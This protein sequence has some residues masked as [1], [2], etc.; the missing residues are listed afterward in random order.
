MIPPRAQ[1]MRATL[2]FLQA[3]AQAEAIPPALLA[4]HYWLDSWVG[5]GLIERGLV[6]DLLRHGSRALRHQSHRLGVG[7][8]AVAGRAG[9][10]V[11]GVEPGGGCCVAHHRAV[12]GTVRAGGADADRNEAATRRTGW[13]VI[14]SMF[15]GS[16]YARSSFS[17]IAA[18]VSG[19]GP[20]RPFSPRSRP[21]ITATSSADSSNPNTS[22]F[23]S[24]RSR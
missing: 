20:T 21:S 3:D 19:C 7:A 6:R 13:I 22:R 10:R 5:I 1:L 4:L 24:I 17:G 9:R 2:G 18:N 15:L 14:A 8:H 12:P 23:S 16:I 11:G